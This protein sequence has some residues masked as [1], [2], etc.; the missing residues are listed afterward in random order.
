MITP[1][2]NLVRKTT[3][4]RKIM[5]F[6]GCTL[7]FGQNSRGDWTV[8]TVSKW[9]IISIGISVILWGAWH[10]YYYIVFS[11]QGKLLLLTRIKL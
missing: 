9:P 5:K 7:D 2:S 6:I 8:I 4:I 3:K 1:I 11:Q 10:S